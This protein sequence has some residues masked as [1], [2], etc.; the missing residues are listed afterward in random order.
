MAKSVQLIGVNETLAELRAV[1]PTVYN[2]MI[3]DV[4]RIMQP[5]VTAI[6]SNIPKISPL[7]SATR[8]RNGMDHN[9]RS[10]L[11]PVKVTPRVFRAGR[12]SFGTEAKFVQI[13]AESIGN[14]FGFEMIDMAGRGNGQ[15]RRSASR[16]KSYPY[17]GGT[18]THRINGQGAAMI[19]KLD[20]K[21]KGSRYTYPAAEASFLGV[22]A[23]VL[24][25]V[26]VAVGK[27]NRRLG[28]I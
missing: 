20:S 2:Q 26:D 27:I 22:Q 9:G 8:G 18:R 5:T 12:A 19:R 11:V 4:K 25:T 6:E 24:K 10:A 13:V 14:K 1:E 7:Y 23:Q 16:T 28:R 17:K 21:G 3:A 15:G